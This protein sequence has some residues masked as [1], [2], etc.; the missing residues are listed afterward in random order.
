MQLNT[1][2]RLI[3]GGEKSTVDFKLRCNAFNSKAGDQAKAKAELVKDICAMA[4]NGSET[5]YLVIGVGD[6]RQRVESVTDA[7]LNSA[8]VQTLVRD[9]LH[10]L[11]LVRVAIQSWP[12]APSPFKGA[13]FFILQIGP[14]PRQAFRFARDLIG[15]GFHFRK[16]EV[17]VRNGDTSGLA[18]PEQ[19]GRLLG[20]RRFSTESPPEAFN[21]IEYHKLAKND[22][23]TA[24]RN[25]VL[26]YFD[27][28]GG[29]SIPFPKADASLADNHGQA[30]VQIAIRGKPF[31]YRLIFVSK[32]S[33]RND[34]HWLPKTWGCEHGRLV[35]VLG[36]FSSSGKH[37]RPLVDIDCSWG[38]LGVEKFEGAY[39]GF[40]STLPEGF[41]P[42]NVSTITL[43]RI[44]STRLV[45]DQL[46][47]L[48]HD[49]ESDD[50]LFGHADTARRGMSKELRRWSRKKA[51]AIR[52]CFAD[53]QHESA[54]EF[55][56][57]LK[58]IAPFL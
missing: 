29:K 31:I 57:S 13:K 30:R 17:W 6:D 49:L 20:M 46:G 35:F 2:L 12:E 32:L 52:K 27:E 53:Y 9:H 42:V 22:Q 44:S 55:Q 36:N 24:L 50:I 40:R 43:R 39:A 3:G 14:N 38:A 28:I 26:A 5:S 51:T 19:I 41:A 25:D 11:P 8:N 33:S 7:N 16:N 58:S 48:L 37:P 47:R 21:V 45:R 18:T 56:R 1:F 34:R 10:P 54:E 15:Q 23:L 4:N